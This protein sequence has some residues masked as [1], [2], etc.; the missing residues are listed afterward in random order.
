MKLKIKVSIKKDLLHQVKVHQALAV[1][2][3][4][5]LVEEADLEELRTVA[6][7]SLAD[8]YRA[9]FGHAKEARA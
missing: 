1:E 7:V 5:D 2:V 8:R 6:H 9:I 4:V 3:L